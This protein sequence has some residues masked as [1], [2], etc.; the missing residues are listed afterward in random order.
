M[1]YDNGD[2]HSKLAQ[3]CKELVHAICQVAEAYL[4]EA[5]LDDALDLLDSDILKLVEGE[6]EPADRLQIQVQQASVLR[7]KGLPN[8][9]YGC[10]DAALEILFEAEKTARSLNDKGLLADIVDLIG[11]VLYAKELWRTALE[12][13]LS[14]FEEG[15]RLRREIGDRRGI[16]E[17]VF[18][19]GL[20]Y[21]NRVGTDDDDLQKA[22]E[23]FQ[24][25]YRLAEQG[26]HIR[27]QAHAARHLAYVYGR[28]GEAGK[29]LTYHKEFLAVNEEIGFKPFLPPA[30]IM[31]GVGY[32][33]NDELDEALACFRKAHVIA[34]EAGFKRYLAE[35]LFGIGV[36]REAREERQEAL[37][38]YQEAL[39]LAEQTNFKR[40]VDLART[41]IENLSNEGR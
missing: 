26:A 40:V 2:S 11:S 3:Y 41:R 21:Q 15:L 34:E 35:A 7:Y 37:G 5:R 19:V 1:T 13:P 22:F 6:L 38:H 10:Y 25:A 4:Y 9:D 31:V 32:L 20:V 28:R 39:T 30:Y 18:N 17:S 16:A 36:V 12:G 33:M 27:E 14:Y 23:R 24:E 29:A 8:N